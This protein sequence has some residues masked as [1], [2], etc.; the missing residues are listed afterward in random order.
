V[1]LVIYLLYLQ[2]L[3]GTLGQHVIGLHSFDP[4]QLLLKEEVLLIQ[5]ETIRVVQH[6]PLLHVLYDALNSLLLLQRERLHLD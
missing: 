1:Q 6:Y 3:P 5:L 2:L 4:H